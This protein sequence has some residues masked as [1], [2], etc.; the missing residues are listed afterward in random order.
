MRPPSLCQRLKIS[1]IRRADNMRQNLTILLWGV[2]VFMLGF[3]LLAVAEYM[4]AS[5][6]SQ[7]VIALI[8]LILTVIG[9]GLTAFGY[10]SLSILR[11]FRFLLTDNR[12]EQDYD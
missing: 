8:G 11:I 1:L 12:S 5:S 7:E 4:L 6:V 10:I 2:A 9:A 3:A